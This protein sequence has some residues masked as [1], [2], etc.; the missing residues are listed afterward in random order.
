MSD[1]LERLIQAVRKKW[2]PEFQLQ[3]FEDSPWNPMR[4]PLKES[5]GV[6]IGTGG[7]YVF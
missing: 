3:R 6:L 4:K 2:V 7:I 5:K 1:K